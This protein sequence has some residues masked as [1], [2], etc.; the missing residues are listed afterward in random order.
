MR[1][2]FIIFTF[3]LGMLKGQ[4]QSIDANYL[5]ND[6][7]MSQQGLPT[8]PQPCSTN[9]NNPNMPIS[10]ARYG[11]K[12]S[13]LS[14]DIPYGNGAVFVILTFIEPRILAE[15]P[16]VMSIKFENSM[17]QRIAPFESVGTA[18]RLVVTV[19][20]VVENGRIK[21]TLSSITG[22]PMIWGIEIVGLSQMLIAFYECHGSTG[23]FSNCDDMSYIELKH[24][25][26]QS[27]R[28]Y[29]HTVAAGFP[30]LDPPLNWKKIMS[31]EGW[32]L[33]Q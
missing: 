4:V 21:F 10:S 8:A 11:Y 9:Y 7:V 22:A 33:T 20:Y 3:A 13:A 2:T 19:P 14:Y 30:G 26:G 1:N 12:N 23:P 16:R 32:V 27:L 17:S 6:C 24:P 18:K 29:G 15:G 25:N 5:P 28:L 31:Q